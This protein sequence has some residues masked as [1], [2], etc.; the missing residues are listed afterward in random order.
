[1]SKRLQV[2]LDVREYRSF[3]QIARETGLSL[4]EWVRQAMRRMA[5]GVSRKRPHSKLK[6]I[7]K[8]SRHHFPTGDIEDILSEIE[9]GRS[10]S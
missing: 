9:R 1:M 7:A 5:E 2:I 3:Q 10:E 4:G 6:V 8:A